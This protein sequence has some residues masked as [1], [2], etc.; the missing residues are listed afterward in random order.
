M[1]ITASYIEDYKAHVATDGATA[2]L[3]IEANGPHHI[4]LRKDQLDE[5]IMRL[6]D[7]SNDLE[8]QRRK[9]DPIAG[10]PGDVTVVSAM[11]ITRFQVGVMEGYGV[12]I[13][14]GTSRGNQSFALETADALDLGRALEREAADPTPWPSRN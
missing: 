6:Q 8:A 11:K 12:G 5:L 3:A 13:V 2:I 4:A 10:K 1:E 14:F 9:V 7:L